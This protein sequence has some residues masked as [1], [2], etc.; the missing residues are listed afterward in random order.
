MGGQYLHSPFTLCRHGT[1]TWSPSVIFHSGSSSHNDRCPEGVPACGGKKK[2]GLI[3]SCCTSELA[4]KRGVEPSLSSLITWRECWYKQN[5]R[6]SLETRNH[7]VCLPKRV[8][9]N[10]S[11]E[12]NNTDVS[13]ANCLTDQKLEKI[14]RLLSDA[15]T[16]SQEMILG[17]I[18]RLLFCFFLPLSL[19]WGK[20]EGGVAGRDKCNYHDEV[21]LTIIHHLWSNFKC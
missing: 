13:L 17:Y 9:K 3:L 16:S 1:T 11:A 20:E 15:V 10:K 19:S 4:G 7:I 14:Q 5:S 8:D 21:V 12:Y 2:D 6:S 18:G